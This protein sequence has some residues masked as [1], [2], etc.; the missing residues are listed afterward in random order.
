MDIHKLC[1]R[2]AELGES[3]Y[4]DSAASG[5]S[6]QTRVEA[7]A[8]AFEP[9]IEMLTKALEK[10]A[11]NFHAVDNTINHTA[12]FEIC[13]AWHCKLARAALAELEWGM[14]EQLL[15]IERLPDWNWGAFL[16][17]TDATCIAI[18]VTEEEARE[19]GERE[20]KRRAEAEEA[21]RMV[22]R[23]TCAYCATGV[24]RSSEDPSTHWNG[25]PPPKC[26]AQG[27]AI[28]AALVAEGWGKR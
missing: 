14:S 25:Y 4:K 21:V 6:G 7:N 16:N 11:I 12:E 2:L 10:V 15:V 26:T 20:L 5:H 24:Q 22:D 23:M 17:E 28:I 1:V 9:T 8:A 3:Y 18:G 19:N 27:R 13:S